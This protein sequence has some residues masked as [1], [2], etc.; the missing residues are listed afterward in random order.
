MIKK[1]QKRFIAITM[2]S[3]ILVLGVIMTSINLAN[4]SQVNRSAEQKLKILADN[5]GV[6]PDQEPQKREKPLDDTP[7][8]KTDMEMSPEAPFDTRYFTVTLDEDG[9]VI[10]VDTGKIAAV[11]TDTATEYAKELSRK[12]KTEGFIEDYK[13]CTVSQQESVMYIFL[14]CNREL[15]TFRSFLWLSVTISIIGLLLVFALVV[16]FSGKAVKPVAESYVKQKRFITD[17]SHEIKTPL[18]IIDANTDVLEMEQGESEWTGSIKKQIQRLTNLTEKLVMLSRMDEGSAALQMIDFCLSEA[19]TDTV[20]PYEAVAK[21]KGKHLQIQVQEDVF[22][23]GDEAAVRQMTALLLDN[24]IKYSEENGTIQVLFKTHGKNKILKVKNSVDKINKGRQ[25]NLFERFY[26]EDA[27]R[28]S[29]TG[30]HGIG[31]SVAQAIVTA[32]KGKISAYSEDGKSI[33]FTVTL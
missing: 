5:N 20:Q 25:D 30:G 1:L 27:S 9:S 13:Y 26:R 7:E 17:A 19:I 16:F 33:E 10:T 32:H 21:A 24:A 11:T 15:S 3:V 29:Q 31:L 12:N 4:Y 14:D 2:C 8:P 18:A 23:H 28:N 6:F 22:Y